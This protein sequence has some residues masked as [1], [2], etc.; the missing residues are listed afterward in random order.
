MLLGN[1]ITPHFFQF[2]KLPAFGQHDM[3]YHIYI[4]NQ[5]PLL[6][7][8]ALVFVGHF[9]TFIFYFIF[10][11]V[12]NGFNLGITVGLANNKKIGNG[13][14]YLAK[15]EADDVFAFFILDG[16][17]YGFENF[18]ATGEPGYAAFFSGI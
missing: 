4:I 7:L 5:Y 16:F 18:A 9:T 11:K 14:G 17:N 3:H 13:F 10:N 12:G 15:V 1:G 2:V 8:P 6:C